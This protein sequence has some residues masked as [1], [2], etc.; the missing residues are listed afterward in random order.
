MVDGSRCTL[1]SLTRDLTICHLSFFFRNS[2]V[3]GDSMNP[4]LEN[5]DYLYGDELK[6]AKKT[7]SAAAM[8]YVA[9]LLVALMQLLRL[10]LLFGRRNN[11]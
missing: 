5:G 10:V 4:S 11:D 3:V 2:P 1:L 7:L 8:T 6:G 9:A